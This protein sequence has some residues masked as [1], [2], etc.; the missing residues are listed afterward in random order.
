MER[1]IL[2]SVVER[3]PE[4]CLIEAA[5]DGTVA[6]RG[7]AVDAPIL[8]CG[9]CQAELVVGVDRRRLTNMVIECKRCGSYN[10]TRDLNGQSDDS[11]P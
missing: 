1:R 2:L 3:D 7:D 4:R 5:A 9:H 11:Y 6:F 8:C 10:D